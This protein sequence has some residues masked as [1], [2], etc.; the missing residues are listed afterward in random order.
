MFTSLV[1]QPHMA[2][3]RAKVDV[4]LH[5]STLCKAAARHERCSRRSCVAAMMSYPSLQAG[6]DE[7]PQVIKCR[8]AAKG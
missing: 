4:S 3:A 6:C 2:G 8:L 5:A 7:L 1:S